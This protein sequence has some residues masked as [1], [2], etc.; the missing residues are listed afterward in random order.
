MTTPRKKQSAMLDYVDDGAAQ[1]VSLPLAG[2]Q[3]AV[4]IGLP[5]GDLATYGGGLTACSAALAVPT[6][7]ALVHLDLPKLA[8]T[9][10]TFSLAEEL[11]AMGM[12]DAFDAN[13][14]DF[15]GLSAHPADGGNLYVFD[16]LQKATIAMAESGVEAAAATAVI[17]DADASVEANPPQ[18]VPMLVDRPYLVSIVDVPTGAVL[19]LGHIEDP[20]DVGTP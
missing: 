8:F 17:L 6:A 10:P 1:I 5:H 19:F 20:T 11:K 12:T 16:V 13:A 15:T 3:L 9:S 4:V 14:A 18:Q 7:Q 2:S